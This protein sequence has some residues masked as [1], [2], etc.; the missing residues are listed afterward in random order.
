MSRSRR[1][2]PDFAHPP[3]IEVALSVQFEPLVGLRTPHIAQFWTKLRSRYPKLEEQQPIEPV[4]EQFGVLRS[5]DEGPQVRVIDTAPVP[6]FWFVNEAGTELIQVQQNRFVVNWRRSDAEAPYP[7]YSAIRR[8]LRRELSAFERF[9]ESERLGPLIPNQGEVTY[10]DEIKPG[11]GWQ[12][13]GQ[14]DQVTTVWKSDEGGFLP[15]PETVMFTARYL[16][17]HEGDRQPRGRLHVDLKSLYRRTERTPIFLLTMTARGVPD[18][19]G[20]SGVLRFMDL[21]QEWIVRGFTS[22]TTDKMHKVWGQR[23]GG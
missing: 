9:L 14:I 13:H 18:G 20:I 22:L 2:R 11:D 1:S 15:E 21:G 10:I 8:R 19:D 12:R 23:D 4:I 5:L 17:H 7:R 6:R 3:V 16:I